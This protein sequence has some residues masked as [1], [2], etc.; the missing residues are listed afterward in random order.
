MTRLRYSIGGL[1]AGIVFVLAAATA[2]ASPQDP[3]SGGQASHPAPARGGPLL[4]QPVSSGFVFTPE[5]KFSSVNH[6]NAT[7]VGGYGGWL[8]D[9]SLL[10]AGA[11]YWLTNGKNG[12]DMWYGGMLVGWTVPLGNVVR[13]GGRGLVGFGWAELPYQY[14]Y[15]YYG[16]GHHQGSGA[17]TTQWAWAATNF[18][19]FEP[20]ATATFRVTKTVAFDVA[21]GYRVIGDAGGFDRELRGGFGSVGVRFGPF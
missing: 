15:E 14:T 8:Y 13:V 6:S 12:T 4:I 21:G 18:F 5:V 20:Q 3:A 17:P 11:A 19:V 2:A 9:E 7:L 10:V 16:S 1:A